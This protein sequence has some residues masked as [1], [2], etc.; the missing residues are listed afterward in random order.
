MRSMSRVSLAA[1]ATGLCGILPFATTSLATAETTAKIDAG[2]ESV[3]DQCAAQM[4]DRSCGWGLLQALA[5]SPQRKPPRVVLVP[6]GRYDA[7]RLAHLIPNQSAGIRRQH[8]IRTHTQK[9]QV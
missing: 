1:V 8:G 6:I 3:G 7:I 9:V 4:P 5:R 2:V